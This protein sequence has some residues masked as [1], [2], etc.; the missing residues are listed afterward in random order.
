VR[1]AEGALQPL[2]LV[3]IL[4]PELCQDLDL[5]QKVREFYKTYYFYEVTESDLDEILDPKE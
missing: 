1:S 5:K 2:W 3:K 4:H